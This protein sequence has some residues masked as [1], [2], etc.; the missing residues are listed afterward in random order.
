MRHHKLEYVL[1]CL[2]AAVVLSITWSVTRSK[3]RDAI[4]PLVQENILRSAQKP[5][6][7]ISD[8]ASRSSFST[9]EINDSMR[10]RREQAWTIVQ[11]AWAPVAVAGGK[12]PA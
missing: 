5:K 6:V 2:S 1:A 9:V 8:N 12:I 11:Q 7:P 10:A 3:N 4:T